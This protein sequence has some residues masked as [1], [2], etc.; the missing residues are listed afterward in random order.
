MLAKTRCIIKIMEINMVALVTAVLGL[1]FV[2][3]SIQVIK[4]RNS[5]HISIGDGN[6]ETLLRAMRAQANFVEFSSIF[7][8]LYIYADLYEASLLLIN[9]IGPIFVIGRLLHIYSIRVREVKEQKINFRVIAIASNFICI[10]LLS[11]CA[12]YISFNSY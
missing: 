1:I 4:L 5:E 8:I 11:I 3:L 7:L 12:L 9:I 2:Y 10:I 6:N